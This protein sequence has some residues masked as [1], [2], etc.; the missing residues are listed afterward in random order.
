MDLFNQR[1][2]TN[3]LPYDGEVLYYP[4]IFSLEDAKAFYQN[5]LSG[6]AWQQDVV[7][8]FGKQFITARKVAWY[9]DDACAYTYSHQTK[10]AL[11]WTPELLSLKNKVEEITNEHYNACLLNLYH[12]GNEGMGWH[13]DDEKSIVPQSAIASLS[14]GAARKFVFKH[15]ESKE[16]V[17]LLLEDASL[18]VMK[19]RT[20]EQWLHALPKTKKVKDL[21]IN[22][23]FRKMIL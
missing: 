11:P 18:L 10:I 2:Q 19:G 7:K 12:S 14:F 23:T 17:S 13:S 8:I 15:K 3:F 20:Q 16:S 6:I 4:N 5:L 21:R 9:G 22:L 1:K